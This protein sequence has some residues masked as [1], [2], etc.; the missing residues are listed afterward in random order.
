MHLQKNNI[1][2]NFRVEN[3]KV[4]ATLEI[5][6]RLVSNPT[7]QSV[8]NDGWVQYTPQPQT[9]IPT[10]EQRVA[11]LIRQQYTIDDE[12]AIQRQRDTKPNEFAQYNAFCEQCKQTARN[13]INQQQNNQ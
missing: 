7:L 6:G 9:Y 4:I 11:E 13:Q 1:Q 10:Y 5:N 2:R 8:L 3:G 12:L